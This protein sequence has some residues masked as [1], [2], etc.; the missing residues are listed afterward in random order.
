MSWG[1]KLK[2]RFGRG[3]EE[4]TTPPTPAIAILESVPSAPVTA[5]AGSR[6]EVEAIV[7][8]TILEQA[9]GRL[10]RDDIDPYAHL[11]DFG[12][13][14]SLSAVNLLA[15]IEAR[16]GVTVDEVDVVGRLST[17]SELVDFVHAEASS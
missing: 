14:D 2:E 8:A 7:L 4:G 12:Y 1:Q 5:D 9:D 10:S 11:F 16:F 6:D 3:S 13:V 15:T 17:L